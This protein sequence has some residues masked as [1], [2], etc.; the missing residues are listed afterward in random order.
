MFVRS[1]LR[2]SY[3]LVLLLA[4]LPVMPAWAGVCRVTTAGTPF[5][6]GSSWASPVS[7]R[8][9]VTVPQI[10]GEIWVAKGVYTPADAGQ[11]Q[12]SFVLNSGVQLYGGFAGGESARE[13]R[14]PAL[15]LTVLSGDI[16]NN[17]TKDQGVVSD[18]L[19]IVGT[20]S[21]HVLLLFNASSSTV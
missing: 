4:V 18:A 15:N 2:P 3:C 5:N 11:P 12:T 1:A 13:Q 8:Q 17:D 14:D 20:N 21:Q 10:C 7:L 6:D 19:G 9:A 16:D